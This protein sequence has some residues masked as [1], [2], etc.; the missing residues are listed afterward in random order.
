MRFDVDSFSLPFIHNRCCKRSGDCGREGG[1][2]EGGKIDECGYC[3]KLINKG[4]VRSD[5]EKIIKEKL[6]Q[7]LTDRNMG[8][9]E[10]K[11]KQ[12]YISILIYR[13]Q[14]RRGGNFAVDRPAGVGLHMHI[15]EGTVIGRTYVFDE[16][17]KALSQTYWASGN[18]SEGA[19]NGLPWSNLLK[20]RSIRGSTTSLRSR[21]ESPF[22]HG[23]HGRQMCPF[24]KGRFHYKLPYI[25]KPL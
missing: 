6:Q 7:S 23:S 2:K 17:Q 14:D 13:F 5:A 21:D 19:Q 25:A 10:G 15:I 16:D 18:F 4:E 1:A 24:E 11:E 20:K 8:Y 9:R 22:C 12:P 3:G